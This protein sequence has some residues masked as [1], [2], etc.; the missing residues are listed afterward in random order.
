M[1]LEI[2]TDCEN[3]SACPRELVV[4]LIVHGLGDRD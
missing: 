1:P 3:D 4:K 2:G